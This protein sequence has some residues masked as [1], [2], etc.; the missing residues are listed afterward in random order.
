MIFWL[1]FSWLTTPRTKGVISISKVA[2]PLQLQSN[3]A[4]LKAIEHQRA[5]SV[6]LLLLNQ[7]HLRIMKQIIPILLIVAGLG[8]GFMGINTFQDSTAS[9]SFLGIDINA[10]DEGGQMAGILYLVLGAVALVAGAMMARKK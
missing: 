4:R 3:N 7:I 2:L 5:T 1:V 9:A 8:L 6:L 10:S